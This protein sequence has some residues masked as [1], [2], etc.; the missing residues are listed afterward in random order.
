[1][2]TFLLKAGR[3]IIGRAGDMNETAVAVNIAKW[4][5]DYPAGIPQLM[6]STP[7]GQRIPLTVTVEDGLMVAVLP[8]TVTVGPGLYVYTAVMT[9]GNTQVQ[10]ARYEC[11]ILG[12]ELAQTWKPLG[13]RVPDWAERIFVAADVIERAMDG[14]IEAR[15]T[16][17]DAAASAEASAEAAADSEGAAALSAQAAAAS[18][19]DAQDILDNVVDQGAAQVS[20]IQ[21]AVAAAR[22]SIPETYTQLSDDVSD[23]KSAT[24]TDR[25]ALIKN[26]QGPAETITI[27]TGRFWDITDNVAS[28][29]SSTNFKCVEQAVNAENVYVVH[30]RI[31]PNQYSEGR[32]PIIFADDNYNVIKAL[33]FDAVGESS[34]VDFIAFVPTGTTKMLIN[35]YGANPSLYSTIHGQAVGLNNMFYAASG[36]KP[37]FSYPYNKNQNTVVTVTLPTSYMYFVKQ[38]GTIITYPSTAADSEFSVPSGQAL[39]WSL[40]T[41]TV[42]V[43][44]RT[45]VTVNDL[46]LFLQLCGYVLCGLFKPF[47]DEIFGDGIRSIQDFIGIPREYDTEDFLNGVISQVQEKQ[48]D[49]GRDMFAFITDTH[50]NTGRQHQDSPKILQCIARN[51]GLNKV[52]TGGDWI[53]ATGTEAEMYQQMW[54]QVHAYKSFVSPFAKV[55][56][57]RGNH[58]LHITNAGTRISLTEQQVFNVMY[59]DM[60]DIAHFNDTDPLGMYFWF[61]SGNLRYLCLNSVQPKGTD[62]TSQFQKQVAFFTNVLSETPADKKFV[63]IT[64]I[65]MLANQSQNY[66]YAVGTFLPLVNSVAQRTVCVIAG[67]NHEDMMDIVDGVVYVTCNADCRVDRNASMRTTET[68]AFDVVCVDVNTS[69]CDLIRVGQGENRAFTFGANPSIIS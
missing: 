11:I 60:E 30:T 33:P 69:R 23:L 55:Y 7:G 28:L 63:W 24:K 1:M 3:Q 6:V 36:K 52:V 57:V 13:P 56:N 17:V 47:Y 4:V 43:K 53:Y 15:T 41:N 46:I 54:D 21:E 12:S 68:G 61:D 58:D 62:E 8:D 5:E 27:S 9:N 42:S 59:A 14:A 20:A 16:A 32:M 40:D 44:A 25:A 10:T 48:L 34:W 29:K 49:C 2:Q 64:H 22:E 65:P 67:H 31:H 51:T 19:S 66:T 45:A 38:D 18:A 37:T 35:S 50:N 26:I 39:V